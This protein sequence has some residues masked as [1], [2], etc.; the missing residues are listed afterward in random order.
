M[1]KHFWNRIEMVRILFENP[2]WTSG[3]FGGFCVDSY[4]MLYK[5]ETSVESSFSRTPAPSKFSSRNL[6][7]PASKSN[8]RQT[9]RLMLLLM[10]FNRRSIENPSANRQIIFEKCSFRSDQYPRPGFRALRT[11]TLFAPPWLDA[12]F[13]IIQSV[14]SN[15]VTADEFSGCRSIC[16]RRKT[17]FQQFRQFNGVAFQ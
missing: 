8:T 17:I 1:W 2:L 4:Y 3:E 16:R 13:S 10:V 9:G 12:F 14:W 6:N 11:S 15:S 5:K 7:C